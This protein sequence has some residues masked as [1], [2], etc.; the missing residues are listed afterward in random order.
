MFAVVSASWIRRRLSVGATL[1]SLVAALV[2]Q[3]AAPE[4][5]QIEFFERQI[6]PILADHCYD[7]HGPQADKVKGSLRLDT[8]AGVLKGGESGPVIVAGKP[9]ESRLWQAVQGKAHDLALMP[10]KKAGR[11]PLKPEQIAALAEWIRQGAPDP[12]TGSPTGKADPARH[13]AFQPPVAAPLPT[14]QARHWPRRELDFFILAQFERLGLSP[15]PEADRRTLLRRITHD[16]TGLPPTPESMQEFLSD[17]APDAYER[18]VERL[19]NSPRYGE[20]WGRH[21]LDVARYADSKGYVFEE[22]RRYA[23]AYTYRDWVVRALNED[24]PYDQFLIQQIAG[25]QVAT[26][27]NPWPMAAAGFLT[28]GRRFLNNEADIIDDRLDVVFRGTQGLTVSC[29]R[30]HDHKFDP[31]PIADYYSLYGVFASS[32]EP[33]EKPLLGPN[34]DPT[35]AAEYAI[36]RARREQEHADHR[37]KGTATVLQT[38]RERTGDYLLT[39]QES[40]TTDAAKLEG[41]ARTRSLDPGLASVWKGRL[42]QFKGTNHPAFAPWFALAALG[43]N[44]FPQASRQY[45]TQLTAQP[46]PAHP[47][48]P[49]LLQ[50]LNEG[51]L[52][53]FA[54]VAGRYGTVLR[55]VETNWRESL[56]KA[57]ETA[58][59]APTALADAGL[60]SLRGLLYGD[61]SPIQE[62][63]RNI[64]RFF[65]VPTAQKGRA[66]RRKVEELDATHPGA[67]LRAMAL[68]DKPQAVEPVIF[69]RGNPGNH[70]PRVPRQ[71]LGALAGPERRPFQNGSGRLELAR[72][73]ASRDNP[74]TARVMVNRVWLRHFGTPLVKTPSDFGVRTEPPVNP[75]LLD[76]LAV[77]FMEHGWSLKQLHRE[78][79]LSATYRQSSDP[80]PTPASR[81]A[82]A[83]HEQ[84]DP[85]N[86]HFWH[87]NRKRFDFEALRDSLLYVSG[88]LDPTFGGQPVEIYDG[89]EAPRRTLYGYI[90]RQNLPGVLRSF[91]FA[92]PD[93][94][95]SMRFQTTVPQQALFLMN[96][97]FVAEQAR[98][99]AARPD[100]ATS[101]PDPVRLRRLHQLAFQRDPTPAEL[102][103]ASRFLGSQTATRTTATP[104]ATWSYGQGE[105]DAATGRVTHFD[106]FKVFKD[107]R[108][109]V[110]NKFPR[111]DAAAYASL[112]AG[113]GHP[114]QTARHSVIRRWTAPLPGSV[115]IEGELDHPG[116]VGDGVRARLVSDRQGLLG[117]WTAKTTKVSTAVASVTV[118]A[119]EI[120]DF[121]V[122]PITSDNTDSFQWAPNLRTVPGAAGTPDSV[123]AQSWEAARDF[124]GP[125]K[126]PVPLNP[127]AK[128]AQVLLS[129]NEFVFVD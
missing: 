65:D 30:C 82:Y 77:R 70:G 86:T 32:Q 101:G 107:G 8:A 28:L 45:L 87:M 31:I 66:L 106:A 57:K 124:R 42:E 88:Q 16:L 96:N 11:E 29:A 22:E 26:K 39:A 2:G 54:E 61:S 84:L 1:G 72:A 125:S 19:L 13:W 6:R 15:A 75:A 56:A 33:G 109:Q 50:A 92:S 49:L 104:A 83:H 47:A 59:P 79:L 117:E 85:G 122:D 67:P 10:P 14:V 71:F 113:G 36:E 34:P 111:E 81:A 73:I 91:D 105:F 62:A 27:D 38:A 44:D 94:S 103:L 20:R 120:L 110:G 116:T 40:L 55:R 7:C 108:W 78:M 25:D 98:H 89:K 24:L 114:G 93:T 99:L 80:G 127:W 64:D 69:K 18:A 35:R 53:N 21:W 119:G 60:E 118:Q 112:L 48:L 51:T 43:T 58:A 17:P 5:A 4:P 90:D 76:L 115:R 68:L 63:V 52:T 41:L 37:A 97:P 128:Y 129:A 95:S 121:V 3:A 123:A 46:A 12:R 9:E 126:D 100:V 23:Y 102:E 74:L